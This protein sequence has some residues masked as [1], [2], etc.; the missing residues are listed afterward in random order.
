MP[1]MLRSILVTK[2]QLVLACFTSA[3]LVAPFVVR[4][5]HTRAWRET[6]YAEF[7]RGNAKGVA[8]RSDG[9]LMPA[10]KFAAFADPNVAYLWALRLDSS[11]RLYAAGGSDAKVVRFDD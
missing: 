4:A 3:A 1:G 8:L 6:D 2:R 10:P 9:K 11:G 5:E 7:E